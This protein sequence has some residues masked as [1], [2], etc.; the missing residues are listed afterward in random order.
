MNKTNIQPTPLVNTPLDMKELAT[1][2][3]KHY[4]IHKGKYNLYL[5]FNIGVGTVG[6]TPEQQ[7]PGAMIGVSRIGLT[8]A[9][10]EGPTTINAE[11]VNPEISSN[12]KVASPSKSLATKKMIAK[13]SSK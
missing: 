13:K 3:L 8:E 4:G 6:P 11:D 5:E 7:T 12:D 9:I 1:F 10:N 2:L